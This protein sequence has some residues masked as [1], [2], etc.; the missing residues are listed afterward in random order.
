MLL[1]ATSALAA[2]SKKA[3]LQTV[4]QQFQQAAATVIGTT[5]QYVTQINGIEQNGRIEELTFGRQPLGDQV[6]P[7]GPLDQLQVVS[8]KS[9]KVC[10]DLLKSVTQ[11]TTDLASLA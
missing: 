6:L 7:G 5:Q 10:S 9:L 2:E 4:T 1:V 11:Y 8:P 3:T